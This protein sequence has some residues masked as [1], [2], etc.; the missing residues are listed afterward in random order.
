MSYTIYE[1]TGL[2]FTAIE[3]PE[4]PPTYI[5]GSGDD[6]TPL[7]T[8]QLGYTAG[9]KPQRFVET[10][11]VLD[12]LPHDLILGKDLMKRAHMLMINP[13]F[14]HPPAHKKFC[15][16]ETAPKNKGE[17]LVTLCLLWQSETSSSLLTPTQLPGQRPRLF[18]SK[19][20]RKRPKN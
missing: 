1:V 13:N 7:G 4:G 19:R 10:F 18:R 2:D 6:T 5:T 8:V 16:L 3:G 14:A 9:I 12:G 17:F 11:Q 15:L 20:L